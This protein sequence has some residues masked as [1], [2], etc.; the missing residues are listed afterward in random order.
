[1]H[2]DGEGLIINMLQPRMTQEHLVEDCLG[3]VGIGKCLHGVVLMVSWDEKT[4]LDLVLSQ[5]GRS[6]V[7][8]VSWDSSTLH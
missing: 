2:C 8:M 6:S 1:M 5:D 3:Q 4:H 7:S